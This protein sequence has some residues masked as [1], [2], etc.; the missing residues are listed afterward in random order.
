MSSWGRAYP[1]MYALLDFTD[2]HS[3]QMHAV[4]QIFGLYPKSSSWK[5][6]EIRLKPGTPFYIDLWT[7]IASPTGPMCALFCR[8]KHCTHRCI[9]RERLVRARD[10]TGNIWAQIQKASLQQA[11]ACW[12]TIHTTIGISST[13]T[14]DAH[15][16]YKSMTL[17]TNTLHYCM[18]L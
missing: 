3:A 18:Y 15:I 10:V 4:F 14:R 13:C 1:M 5:R 11:L 9:Q 8:D 16:H 6:T 17:I 2:T 7:C 12:W